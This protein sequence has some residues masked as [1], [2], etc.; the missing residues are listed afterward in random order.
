MPPWLLAWF[1]GWL[2]I[3]HPARL[4][5]VNRL[6]T[7]SLHVRDHPKPNKDLDDGYVKNLDSI[8]FLFK[9]KCWG[10]SVKPSRE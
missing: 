1:S 2:L 7:Q 8:H 3:I 5:N 4:E 9:V 10:L 6:A